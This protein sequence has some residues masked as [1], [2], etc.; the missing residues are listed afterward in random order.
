MPDAMTGNATADAHVLDRVVWHALTGRQRRFALGEGRARRFPTAI[1][2]FAAIDDTSPASFDALCELIAAHGPAALVTPD[3][4]EAPAS[5]SAIRRAT[6]LQMTWQ[7]TLDAAH[8][9]EPVPLGAAD[10]PDM[11][12]LA[13]AAQPGPFGPRTFELGHYIGVRSEGRLAA[14]AGQRMQVEGYTEISAVCVDAAFRRQG[15]AARLIRSLI[16]TISARAETP[17]LHV[18]TTN[19]VAIERY[20][21]LG[22]VV[23]REMHLLVLGD[24]H[25]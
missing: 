24:A 4:I 11:L 20:L 14:M 1:A 13:A 6:L 17:F 18:L 19:Q 7:G 12:A 10:V 3:E 21:A 22:F 5:L 9:A 23:R 15:L 16:A 8:E 2:P 25:T